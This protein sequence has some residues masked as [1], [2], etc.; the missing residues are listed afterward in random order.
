M[1]TSISL[2]LDTRRPKKNGTFPLI[3]HIIHNRTKAQILTGTYLLEKDW[4]DDKKLIKSSFK[5]TDSVTRLN[6]QIL[7]KKAELS[8]FITDL[9]DAK[10]LAK[11]QTAHQ[12][13]EL[14]IKKYESH[15][16]FKYTQKLI[17]E[18]RKANR[19]GN[20]RAYEFVLNILKSYCKNKELSFEE[21]NYSFLMKFEVDHLAKGNKLNSLA[22]YMRTIRAI[23]NRAIKDGLAEK[24]S[25]P[26]ENYK[27]RTKK[28]NKRAI[29]VIAIAKIEELD[30]EP[31]H[32]FY[33]TRNY[34]LFCYNMRGMPFADMAH[35][36]L[37]NIVDGR[38]KFDRQKTEKGYNIK[39]TNDAQKILDIY[40]V[41]K[42]K[43][44]FIFPVIKRTTPEG[45]YKDIEWARNRYNKKLKK[46]AVLCGINENL[47]SYVSRHSFAT[48]AKNLG[49][50]IANI[51]DMLGHDSIKTT[52]IYLDTLPSDIM[53]SYHEQ[54]LEKPKDTT[55]KV[56]K[57]SLKK[58]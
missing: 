57:K 54:I 23:Y 7:K 41:G 1:A 37:S 44:D 51:S 3:L 43:D 9:D 10:K 16:V 4:S 50:P 24:S 13:K 38:I 34:F 36:K 33:K 14:F 55:T 26:F 29:N 47:T 40:I 25:Y 27:I 35:L 5:D 48:R 45:Q 32:P 42:E 52:E 22:V 20:A 8:S 58:K 53:D 30:L 12:I 11:I 56:S 18:M 31:N 17:D 39:I 2:L 49:I 15:S 6:N 46:L 28:T 19:I 21:L